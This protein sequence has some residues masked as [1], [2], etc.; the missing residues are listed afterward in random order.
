MCEC[1]TPVCD[2]DVRVYVSAC[3]CSRS[4]LIFLLFPGHTHTQL[5]SVSM[6]LTILKI[7]VQS[8]LDLFLHQSHTSSHASFSLYVSHYSICVTNSG[9]LGEES[10]CRRTSSAMKEKMKSLARPPLLLSFTF[11]P[12]KVTADVSVAER[13]QPNLHEVNRKGK[14]ER[15]RI[16]SLPGN[17]E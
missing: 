10:R 2:R 13:L 8:M 11:I 6:H 4:L 7:A 16:Y 15:A 14:E 3:V 9:A 12:H 5:L 17:G 1:V